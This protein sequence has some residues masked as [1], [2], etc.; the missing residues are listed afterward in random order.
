MTICTWLELTRTVRFSD[1]DAA[2]VVHFQRLLGWC[3]QAW[4]ASLEEFGVPAVAVFPGGPKEQPSV[5]LPIVYCHANFCAPLRIGDTVVIQLRPKRLNPSCF[6][7]IS[8]LRL[9]DQKVASGCLRHLAI[10]AST[11]QRCNLPKPIEFWLKAAA[12]SRI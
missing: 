1:T 8:H 2:G 9:D 11:R 3:H 12:L 10:D 6:E 7:V 5:A 4:E